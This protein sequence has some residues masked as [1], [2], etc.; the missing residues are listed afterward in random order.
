MYRVTRVTYHYKNGG[1]ANIN[2]TVDVADVNAYRKSLMNDS[3]A[4]I[5]LTY[6]ELPDDTRKDS[7]AE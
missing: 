1:K 2:E 4:R 3:C 7:G 6:K 5:N